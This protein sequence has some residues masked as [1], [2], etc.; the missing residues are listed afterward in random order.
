MA[1]HREKH[2]KEVVPIMSR[3]DRRDAQR[4]RRRR[5][6]LAVLAAALAL[7]L[8][9]SLYR[10]GTI[11]W[12]YGQ[13]EA[14]VRPGR[15]QRRHG[16]A[17]PHRRAGCVRPSGRNRARRLAR[18]PAGA[19]CGG[20]LRAAGHQP[21]RLRLALRPGRVPPLPGRAG[22]GQRILPQ[23]PAGRHALGLRLPVRGR[24][25]GRGLLGPGDDRLRPQHERRLHV[26]HAGRLQV[27]GGLRRPPGDAAAD[28]GRATTA[29]SCWRGW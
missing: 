17:H 11:L 29:W 23:P 27:P 7:L 19:P 25:R 28:P 8:L 10:V 15:A 2:A 22:R 12:T 1:Y 18:G 9:Y 5:T 3:M 26:R 20:L 6:A 14:P 21:G 16:A 24:R 13:G 4:A